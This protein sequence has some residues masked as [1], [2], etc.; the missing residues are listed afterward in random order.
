MSE[1]EYVPGPEMESLLGYDQSTKN[2]VLAGRA[3]LF[4][5]DLDM[6]LRAVNGGMEVLNRKPEQFMNLLPGGKVIKELLSEFGQC[7]LTEIV[8]LEDESMTA[9]LRGQIQSDN[10]LGRVGVMVD[11]HGSAYLISTQNY[12]CEDDTVLGKPVDTNDIKETVKFTDK[13]IFQ[14]QVEKAF[15]MVE[16]LTPPQFVLTTR[17]NR[18]KTLVR[19][20]EMDMRA[21]DEVGVIR[22]ILVDSQSR[23]F[24][25]AYLA[26]MK[27]LARG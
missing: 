8:T 26:G 7:C 5:G 20:S 16:Q 4:S 12:V 25:T 14:K 15:V 21:E 2:F 22:S 6:S 13:R 10:G 19:I 11:S 23:A 27:K 3:I 1:K 17:D 18:I 9:I 24:Y